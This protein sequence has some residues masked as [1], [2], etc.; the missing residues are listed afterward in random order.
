MTSY[1]DAVTRFLAQQ[2]E[3]KSDIFLVTSA[4][5]PSRGL[6][7]LLGYLGKKSARRVSC[8]TLH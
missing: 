5:V 4:R 6:Q 8:A 7:I 3:G 2:V 1:D